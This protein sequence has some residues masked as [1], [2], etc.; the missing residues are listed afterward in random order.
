MK[1][2]T[3]MALLAAAGGGAAFFLRLAQRRTGFSPD[4]GLSVPGNLPGLL[5]LILLALLLAGLFLLAVGLP[6]R[7]PDPRPFQ[8]V[9]SVQGTAAPLLS[10]ASLLALS[11]AGEVKAA[12]LGSG[13]GLA[14]CEDLPAA[15]I[16][17]CGGLTA[18]SA[19]C[20]LPAIFSAA[21]GQ[22]SP[23]RKTAPPALL[24][25]APVAL[26]GRLVLDYRARSVS[27]VPVAYAPELLALGLSALAFFHLASFGFGDGSARRFSFLA[28][29]AA[30]FCTA[31]L[32]DG[33]GLARQSLFAGCALFFLGLLLSLRPG[34]ARLR[35]RAV[36]E[37]TP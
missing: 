33:G 24:L 35:G 20:L 1:H 16:L 22:R 26:V 36:R 4:T 37:E 18:I 15:A 29:A 34:S 27:P 7:H 13:I 19:A 17:V 3:A 10:G 14:A 23:G 8:E 31:A 5:L 25:F 6:T 21:A 30:V 2:T 32:A 12:L 11:G 28:G 9:F